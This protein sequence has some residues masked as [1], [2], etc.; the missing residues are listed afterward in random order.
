MKGDNAIARRREGGTVK[1]RKLGEEK[2][3]FDLFCLL[4]QAHIHHL[5]FVMAAFI[6]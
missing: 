5:C 4:L 3:D 6:S 1:Q 2:S